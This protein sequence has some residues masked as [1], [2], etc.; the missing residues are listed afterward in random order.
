M[1]QDRQKRFVSDD[2]EDD[3]EIVKPK[4]EEEEAADE[5]NAPHQDE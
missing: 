1:D 2:L 4:K 5:R 3:F